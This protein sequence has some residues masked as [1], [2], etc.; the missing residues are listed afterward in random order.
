M[1]ST[2]QWFMSSATCEGDTSNTNNENTT[3]E[4]SDVAAKESTT[5]E[6]QDVTTDVTTSER[7]DFYPQGT[8]PD[9]AWICYW[10][11]MKTDDVLLLLLL[12]LYVWIHYW[13]EWVMQCNTRKS[14]H[15]QQ[16]IVTFL[17]LHNTRGYIQQNILI[18]N[19]LVVHTYPRHP[20]LPSPFPQECIENITQCRLSIYK[21]TSP[22]FGF[23]PCFSSVFFV[24]KTIDWERNENFR[25]E[26]LL[27]PGEEWF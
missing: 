6:P 19:H 2:N 14:K 21:M 8:I 12:L 7:T 9:P 3:P 23:F 25:D 24:T 10:W 1:A 4:Q 16:N 11:M 26:F 22:I 27:L 5:T 13:L 20:L 15:I 17:F 18:I